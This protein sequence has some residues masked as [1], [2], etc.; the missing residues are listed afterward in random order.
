MLCESFLKF[1]VDGSEGFFAMCLFLQLCITFCVGNGN[2]PEVRDTCSSS[3]RDK[4]EVRQ[5]RVMIKKDFSKV[6]RSSRN[7]P[8]LSNTYTNASILFICHVLFIV[9]QCSVVAFPALCVILGLVLVSAKVKGQRSKC[10][11]SLLASCFNL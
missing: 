3:V 9:H 11:S 1:D 4:Q 7:P 5:V 10:Q 6:H 8:H 2:Y